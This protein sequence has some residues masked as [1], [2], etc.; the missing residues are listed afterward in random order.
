MPRYC[1]RQ[2]GPHN[3]YG[4]RSQCPISNVCENMSSEFCLV[5]VVVIS[6]R[7]I[8]IEPYLSSID[9]LVAAMVYLAQKGPQGVA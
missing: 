1:R 5:F 8:V 7:P 2:H 4:S 9:A 6:G 3:A